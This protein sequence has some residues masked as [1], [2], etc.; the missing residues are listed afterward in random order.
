VILFGGFR[1]GK[2]EMS[3]GVGVGDNVRQ[4]GLGDNV[5]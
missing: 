2:P 4:V 1:Q 5:R 3:L